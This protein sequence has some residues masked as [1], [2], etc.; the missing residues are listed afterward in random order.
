LWDALSS[1]Y[2]LESHELVLLESAART[3][4]LIAD[5]QAL[6]DA[7][8][9]KGALMVIYCITADQAFVKLRECSQNS[10]IKLHSIAHKL[11]DDIGELRGRG[12]PSHTSVDELLRTVHQR[13]QP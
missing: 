9:L 10:N 6:I 11:F 4:D 2:E 3:A 7:E 5:L 1:D 12:L 8:G 13:I